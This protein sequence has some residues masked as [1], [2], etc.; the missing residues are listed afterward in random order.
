MVDLVLRKN[1]QRD[2][3][4]PLSTHTIKR[5]ELDGALPRAIR[6]SPRI[7]AY[8]R[9]EIKAALARLGGE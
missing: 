9:T 7:F 4:L 8:H 1:L 2:G 6:V 3:T 5:L